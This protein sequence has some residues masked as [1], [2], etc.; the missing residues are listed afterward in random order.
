MFGFSVVISLK[1][2]KRKELMGVIIVCLVVVIGSNMLNNVIADRKKRSGLDSCRIN[3]NTFF[4][5]EP[6]RTADYED[7]L[8][9]SDT[10]Y[11]E[12]VG[13]CYTVHHTVDLIFNDNLEMQSYRN[14][15]NIQI[16]FGHASVIEN[17][18]FV[19]ISDDIIE[20]NAKYTIAEMV[21]EKNRKTKKV[22]HVYKFSKDEFMFLSKT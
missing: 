15:I 9:Y 10:V 22:N 7:I 21:G 16:T 5:Q 11:F 13:K 8:E 19:T 12:E 6:Y 20:V 14:I 18:S 1:T 17:E 4:E 2:K 3:E